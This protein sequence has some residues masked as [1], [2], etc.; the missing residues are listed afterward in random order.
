MKISINTINRKFTK[1]FLLVACLVT[2]NL[3]AMGND[4]FSQ[5]ALPGGSAR[6]KLDAI[7]TKPSAK[8]VSFEDG[9]IPGGSGS[10]NE[11]FLNIEKIKSDNSWSAFESFHWLTGSLRDGEGKPFVVKGA[12]HQPGE[13]ICG[14]EELKD[15][16]VG[17]NLLSLKH[18]PT[19]NISRVTRAKRIEDTIQEKNLGAKFGVS[20]L[21]LYPLSGNDADLQRKD[22]VDHDV[23]VV[24][25]SVDQS[26]ANVITDT[27]TDP[28]I[29]PRYDK[30][31]ANIDETTYRGLKSIV[32]DAEV[33]DTHPSNIVFDDQGKIIFI[34]TED[35]DNL[36]QHKIDKSCRVFRPLK[37]YKLRCKRRGNIQGQFAMTAMINNDP[38]I[39]RDGMKLSL[40]SMGNLLISPYVFE[41]GVA[42]VT[43][44]TIRRIYLV[45][46]TNKQ[47][48][49]CLEMIR[50]AI[51]EQTDQ[52]GSLSDEDCVEIARKIVIK[53][54]PHEKRE[55]V[56]EAFATISLAKTAEETDLKD[57]KI[58]GKEYKS[59]E[60]A[61]R[62]SKLII[63]S[64]WRSDWLIPYKIA[65]G[66]KAAICKLKTIG[67]NLINVFNNKSS[68]SKAV[69]T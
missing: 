37:R 50:T 16:W 68:K 55:N 3:G 1:M 54:K 36:Q 21:G 10:E 13:S 11:Q 26:K 41:I 52:K 62:R 61:V 14:A 19:Q 5:Y 45:V 65:R 28:L 66:T 32:F 25:K 46:K 2:S 27:T 69:T 59:P 20:A 57:I 58:L 51:E 24:E 23:I 15:T 29:Q 6:S 40:K 4:G 48:K 42:A 63:N 30:R 34:D 17:K 38:N 44:L 18:G 39:E 60:E 8:K 64:I 31:L 56:F 33:Q 67:I 35:S 43:A 9:S 12:I 47:I 49:R 7:R 53:V 22:L